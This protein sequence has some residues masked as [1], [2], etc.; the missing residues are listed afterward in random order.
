MK[1]QKIITCTNSYCVMRNT[2]F[3]SYVIILYALLFN[4]FLLSKIRYPCQ[5]ILFSQMLRNLHLLADTAAGQEHE[6]KN[7]IIP[8]SRIMH[9]HIAHKIPLYSSNNLFVVS[10]IQT[11]ACRGIFFW[12][13]RSVP[14]PWVGNFFYF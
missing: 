3:S 2:F 6:C 14:F 13:G 8:I 12:G 11:R 10:L 7:K 1:V 4:F 9:T 5:N